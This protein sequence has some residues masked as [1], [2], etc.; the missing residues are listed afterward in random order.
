[1]L[2]FSIVRSGVQQ[3]ELFTRPLTEGDMLTD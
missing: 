1:M 2:N 3:P